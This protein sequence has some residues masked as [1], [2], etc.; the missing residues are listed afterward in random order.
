[1]KTIPVQDVALAYQEYGSGQ[2]IVLLH[3]FCGSSAYWEQVIPL[4][5]DAGRIIVPDLRGHGQS[6]APE[7]DIYTMEAYAEDI[8]QLLTALEADHPIVLGHSLGGYITLALAEKLG[9]QAGSRLAGFGLIHSTAETDTPQG[10]DGRDKGIATIR[11][12]G[13]A[14]FV[15]GLIPKL[16][17]PAHLDSMPEQVEQAKAIGYGTSA[18]AAAATQQ[19]MKER[20]DRISVLARAQ[21]PVLL[22][23]G[24]HVG[25]IP[26]ERTFSTVQESFTPVTLEAAGHMSMLEAPAELA[27]IIRAFA[28]RC[29]S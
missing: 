24:A 25:V 7:Q 23:A 22:V 15:D 20:A 14:A 10:R 11:E 26:P 18:T 29:S 16:F 9:S 5:Q 17:A 3:G 1:M 12:F 4:L 27:A 19:G 28:A 8:E 2:P 21:V 6:S 13:I